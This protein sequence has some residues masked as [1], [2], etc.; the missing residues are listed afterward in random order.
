MPNTKIN[1][2]IFEETKEKKIAYT[3]FGIIN[4]K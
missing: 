2:S 3:P 4:G 1:D